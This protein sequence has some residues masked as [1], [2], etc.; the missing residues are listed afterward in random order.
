[1]GKRIRAQ[2]R[3]KGSPTF[4]VPDYDFKPNIAFS[5]EPCTITDIVPYPLTDAP[6]A[7]L[8]TPDG[9]VSYIPAPEGCR[10]GQQA[11]VQHLAD[12]P[13]GATVFCLETQPGIGPKLCRAPGSSATIISRTASSCVIQLPSKKLRT[14]PLSCRAMIG[15][16]AGEG[17]TDKPFLKAGSR[18]FQMHQRGKIYPRTSGVAMNAVDHPHGGS[19]SGTTKPPKPRSASPGRKVGSFASRATGR[20]R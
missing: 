18:W 15:T 12:I 7:K 19:G 8:Q 16:A 9:T 4:R 1:M 11:P 6:L 5:K 2:K 10:V 17:R 13:D 20:Q 14:F 3:G